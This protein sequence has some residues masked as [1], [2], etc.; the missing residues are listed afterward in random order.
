VD[1]ARRRETLGLTAPL[2]VLSVASVAGTALAPALA[3]EHSLLLVT[4]CPRSIYVLAAVAH[5]P[6]APLVLLATVRLTM[7]DPLHFRLGRLHGA[8]VARSVGRW[9]PVA[10]VGAPLVA[11]SPTG[12]VLA[13]AG[14]AGTPAGRVVAADLAGTLVRLAA[15]CGA[16][17]AVAPWTGRVLDGVGPLVALAPLAMV[18]A[19]VGL[20]G[21]RIAR[22]WSPQWTTGEAT[23]VSW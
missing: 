20:A 7:A 11:V 5:V 13:L 12:K 21:V 19:L 8:G 2:A 15:L 10:K 4:L 23:C 14:A 1:P 22:R 18:T 6:L 9:F 17:R 3:A 16:G